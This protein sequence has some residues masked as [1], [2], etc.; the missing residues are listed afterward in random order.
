MNRYLVRSLVAILTFSIGVAVGSIF[1][2]PTPT[3]RQIRHK[4][5]NEFV[6][7]RRV[8]NIPQGPAPSVAIDNDST[9]P[10]KLR[11]SQT[12]FNPNGI[13]PQIVEFSVE[14]TSRRA[15]ANFTISYRSRWPSRNQD[16]GDVAITYPSG[17]SSLGKLTFENVSIECDVDETLSVWVSAVEFKDGSSWANPR[18]RFN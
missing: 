17:T 13:K 12:R 5:C 3:Y 18:H 9:D 6:P 14:P 2:T 16:G 15:I 8:V 1:R 11:Y 4:R 10:V 7:E